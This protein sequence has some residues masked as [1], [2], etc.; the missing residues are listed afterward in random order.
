MLMK[1]GAFSFEFLHIERVLWDLQ[2]FFLCPKKLFY[3][4]PFP[5]RPVVSA[6]KLYSEYSSRF[7]PT[8][9]DRQVIS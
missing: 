8:S 3:L 4:A 9:L 2:N 1:G 6:D 7:E 5:R